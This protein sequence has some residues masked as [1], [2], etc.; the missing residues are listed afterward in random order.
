M[1]L[2][3]PNV[4]QADTLDDFKNILASKHF[5]IKYTYKIDSDYNDT[6]TGKGA[7]VKDKDGAQIINFSNA[8][9]TFIEAYDGNNFYTEINAHV[10]RCNLKI[11]DKLF[12]F[13]KTENN[14]KLVYNNNYKVAIYREVEE[15]FSFTRTTTHES[16]IGVFKSYEYNTS[17]SPVIIA[18]FN[19]EDDIYSGIYLYRHAGSGTTEDGLEYF[20]LKADIGFDR[21]LNAIRYYFDGGVIKKIV[22][23][24]YSKSQQT[25]EITGYKTII[26][27]E[28]FNT[29][30]D[31]KYFKLPDSFKKIEKAQW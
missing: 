22:F 12:S 20:D 25:G 15:D 28:E 6:K 11:G 5:F 19:E 21:Y 10:N 1:I 3:L 31:P 26:D 30:P 14:G 17:L 18:L 7:L 16:S 27:V 23:A 24:F 13:T 29:N 8:K 4:A 2:I 9:H